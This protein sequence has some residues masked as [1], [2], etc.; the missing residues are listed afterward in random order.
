MF[1]PFF[2]FFL[3]FNFKIFKICLKIKS[4]LGTPPDEVCVQLPVGGAAELRPRA[5]YLVSVQSV[6]EFGASEFSLP[7]FVNLGWAKMKSFIFILYFAYFIVFFEFNENL[8][9]YFSLI[10]FKIM[11]F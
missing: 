9:L 5:N 8:F 6:D 2:L 10:K 4:T 1:F 3:V 7:I 11:Y